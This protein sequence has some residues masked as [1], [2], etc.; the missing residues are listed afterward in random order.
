LAVSA[1]T[2]ERLALLASSALVVVASGTVAPALVLAAGAGLAGSFLLDWRKRIKQADPNTDAAIAKVQKQVL[3]NSTY[4]DVNTQD[5]KNADLLQQADK[6]LYKHIAECWPDPQTIAKLSAQ[7]EGFPKRVAEYVVEKVSFR[8]ETHGIF[9]K[10]DVNFR[11]VAHD[12]AMDTVAAAMMVALADKKYFQQLQPHLVVENLKLSSKTLQAVQDLAENQDNWQNVLKLVTDDILQTLKRIDVTTQRTDQTTQ[13][14]NEMVRQLLEKEQAQSG[15]TLDPQSRASTT[16]TYKRLLESQ[17]GARARA[18]E[19]VTAS[20]PDPAGAVLD[21]KQL[22]AQQED[23]VV[24]AALTWL[25][26][27]NIAYLNDTDDALKAFTRVTQLTPDNPHGWNQSGHLRLRVGDLPAAKIAFDRVLALGETM[28]DKGLQATALGNLGIV[29]KTLGN[30]DAAVEYYQQSLVLEKELGRKEGM[31]DNYGNLGIVEKTLGNLD[32]AVEYYQQSLV[33]EQE[34]GRKEGMA[35][36]YGNLGVVEKIKGNLDAAVGYYQQALALNS[37]LGRKQGIA[38]NYGNLGVV[39]QIRGR[40]DAAVDYYQQALELNSELGRKESMAIQYGNLGNVEQRLGNLDAA[41]DYYKQS[42]ALEK[43]LGRKEGMAS[44]YGNLG[45]VEK[46]RG[47][48]D[49]AVDYYKQALALN[50]ELGRKQGIAE[51]YSN[52]GVV[53]E[54]RG[55]LDAAVA[56]Y[57]QALALNLELGNKQGMGINHVNLGIVEEI[58]GNLDAACA[59][60]RQAYDLFVEVGAAPQIEQVG[61]W[62]RDAGCSDAP[63]E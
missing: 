33:L 23:A 54:I 3:G 40:L 63:Q 46:T 26:I 31:A 28:A 38:D 49:A 19:K 48:L 22:A 7:G 39:E 2:C 20:P 59:Y 36:D 18:G 58:R 15:I 4:K 12:F 6:L 17:K 13:D 34:L 50:S 53:E 27:G 52:L 43:E 16:E 56:Y 29:E 55:N 45:I 41:V 8:I 60:W 44:D 24:D 9:D 62:L 57:K 30:L 51:N 37:E 35:S 25:D 1:D 42:L 32:A 61:N 47:N 11:Q 21:L 10:S 14:T 5:G